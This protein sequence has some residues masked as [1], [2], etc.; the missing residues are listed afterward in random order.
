MSQ[1]GSKYAQSGVDYSAM[2]PIKVLAQKRAAQTAGNLAAFNAHEVT[3]SRGESAYVWDEGD[4]YRSLVVEGLGTKNL[5]ADAMRQY[6]D[7][8]YYDAIAQDTIAMVVNDL[9]VV[10]ALPQV[11]NAY[12]AIGDS[13]WMRDEKRVAD[14]INGWA[15]ACDLAGATWGG[16]ETPTLKGIINPETI[17]LGGSAVGIIQNKDNLVLGEKLAAGDKIILVASSG[18]HAN[19]LT[20][21]RKVG[22]EAAEG[23]VT[24]LIDGRT[25]GEALLTPTPIYVPIVRALQQANIDIHYMVN[26][27]GHGWR[28]LMR[29]TKD[30][31]YVIDEVPE[32]PAEFHFIQDQTNSSDN[33]MYGNFNMGAGYAVYVGEADAEKVVTSI[34]EQGFKAII[35]GTVQ[36]GPKQVTITPMNI[37]FSGDTLEVR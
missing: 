30:F 22:D 19:G 23:Y 2:D 3:D 9:I 36:D 29:S 25:Y 20:L 7:K 6:G 24:K 1:E 35:A 10:G 37:T 21:A 11:V 5:V 18:I 16:G 8:T 17:D 31:N 33:D 27:T 32:V 14:L 26:I 28:K 15:D 13:N 4:S 34:N 12:F